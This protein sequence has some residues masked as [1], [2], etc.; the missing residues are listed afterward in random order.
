MHNNNIGKTNEGICPGECAWVYIAYECGADIWMS[1]LNERV[2]N[3]C[4]RVKQQPSAGNNGTE[5]L[6]YAPNEAF[7]KLNLPGEKTEPSRN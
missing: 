6:K 4:A 7:S 3:L 2:G 5:K 1:A